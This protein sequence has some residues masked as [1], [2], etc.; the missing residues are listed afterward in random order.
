MPGECACA[1]PLALA[2]GG[3][4]SVPG[5]LGSL[6]LLQKLEPIRD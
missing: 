2:F 5:G 3:E 4:A 1:R 6:S